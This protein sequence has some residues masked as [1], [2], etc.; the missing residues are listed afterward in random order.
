M[1]RMI[2]IVVSAWAI[3]LAG[4]R[5]APMMAGP[6]DPHALRGPGYFPHEAHQLMLD[7]VDCHHRYEN[8]LNVVTPEELDG[9]DAMRCRTCHGPSADVNF[10]QAIHRQ[11]IRCHCRDGN[12]GGPV[13]CGGCHPRHPPSTGD[14]LSIS[15]R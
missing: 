2:L 14:S 5:V 11:C 12:T 10:R 15:G 9:S 7:C 13:T 8:G 3:I 1:D 4:P 6:S